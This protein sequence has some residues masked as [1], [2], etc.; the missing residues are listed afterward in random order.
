M[1]VFRYTAFDK[2]GKQVR[3]QI[4][5]D[6]LRNVSDRLRADGLLPTDLQEASNKGGGNMLE[7][8]RAAWKRSTARVNIREIATLTRQLATLVQAGLPLVESLSALVEQI[9]NEKLQQILSSVRDDVNEGV[10]LADALRPF[11]LVFDDLFVN[12]V[13][14]GETSG[15]LEVVLN[16][17]ADFIESQ[18]MLRGKIMAALAYPAVMMVAM[19]G[20]IGILFTVVVPKIIRIFDQ[21][22]MDLPIYTRILIAV[23]NFFND[24]GILLIPVIMAMAWGFGQWVRTEKGR[25]RWDRIKF[26]I[27]IFKRLAL[28][29][30]LG[31]FARTLG[32]LLKN[33][34]EMRTSL[35]IVSEVVGNRVMQKVID[36]TEIAI[37]EGS[38]LADPLKRSGWFPPMIIHM[39]S[40]GERSGDLENMLL[41][42]AETYESD[43][44]SYIMVM[45]G[46]LE[47]III[48]VMASLVGF[49]LISIL[50]PMFQMNSLV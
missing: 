1:P 40:V 2:A 46:L 44:E 29:V 49:I 18:A 21:S 11:P 32:T 25:A 16:R 13:R 20:V 39:I 45:T 48:I 42:V 28:Y 36:E 30:A 38:T 33:G 19:I 14:A 41:R 4:D 15:T 17:L 6:N 5:G 22:G 7:Q 23:V 35:R 27:P 8:L 12:M 24:Y 50:L 26:R 34:V 43:V 9:E 37:T 3:G 47:P 31:R 10:S